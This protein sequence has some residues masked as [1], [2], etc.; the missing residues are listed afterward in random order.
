MIEIDRPRARVRRAAP[1]LEPQPEPANDPGL[2][3]ARRWRRALVVIVTACL[4]GVAGLG[5]QMTWH[6][7]SARPESEVPLSL[8]AVVG[9][10]YLEPSSTVVRIGAQGGR[11]ATRVASV[12]VAEGDEVK[13]GQLLAML[14]TADRLAAEVSAATAQ[15][16]LK[17]LM[18]ERQKLDLVSVTAARKAVLERARAELQ[19]SRA[20]YE[21]QRTL[22][23]QSNASRAKF[24]LA[25]RNFLYAQASLDEAEAAWTRVQAVDPTPARAGGHTLLDIAVSE[26]EL[27]VAEADLKVRQASLEEALIRAPFSG[28]V[29]TLHARAGERI[30]DDGLLEMGAT[31]RM[32]AV[33][34]VYQTDIG[35]V[36]LGQEVEL[37]AAAL[38]GPLSGRV[39]RVG[40]AVE[41]QT[42]VNN[43]PATATDARVVKVFVAL[44]DT[45]SH[46]VALLSRL[47]VQALFR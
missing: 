4:L 38:D 5:L 19:M 16:G 17:R 37:R 44:D 36:R 26:Q 45:A 15:A 11:D 27:A 41:R 29:L 12:Q 42:V 1:A 33:I 35:R 3:P 21:R 43:D 2:P 6:E 23:A 9:L 32:R 22:T 20:E 28:R 10:G 18:L 24:E 30:G 13:Q 34:E 7:S 31:D 8:P 47:Q 40:A 14:D 39:E 46:Q 25:S